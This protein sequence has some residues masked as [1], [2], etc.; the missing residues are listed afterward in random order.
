MGMTQND[1]SMFPLIIFETVNTTKNYKEKERE[2]E[3]VRQREEDLP[4]TT[5]LYVGIETQ[6][7]Y[8]RL[9]FNKD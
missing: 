7:Y 5:F 6:K 1:S 3:R 8:F 2:K 9:F 4:Q